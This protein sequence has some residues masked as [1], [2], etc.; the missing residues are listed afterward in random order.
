M[1]NKKYSLKRLFNNSGKKY[2]HKRTFRK[3]QTKRHHKSK[4]Y[5]RGG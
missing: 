2:K 4:T 3:R 5:M 1:F